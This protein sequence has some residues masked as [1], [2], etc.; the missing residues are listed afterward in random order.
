MLN[1]PY[2]APDEEPINCTII[3]YETRLRTRMF[4]NGAAAA[5]I[6][7][8]LVYLKDTRALAR[9]CEERGLFE[10]YS[11][12]DSIDILDCRRLPYCRLI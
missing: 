10:Y 5:T 7:T 9:I 6:E 3:D 1:I 11:P 8:Y 2:L 4:N 12:L